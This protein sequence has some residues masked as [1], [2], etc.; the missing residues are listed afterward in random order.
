MEEKDF[1]EVITFAIRKEAEAYNLYKYLR[2]SEG[3]RGL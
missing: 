1:K 2:Y 3:G